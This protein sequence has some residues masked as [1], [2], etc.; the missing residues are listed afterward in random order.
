GA[1]VIL[2]G[3][4]PGADDPA[5]FQESVVEMVGPGAELCPFSATVNVVLSVVPDPAVSF[6]EGAAAMR[7]AAARAAEYLAA[8]AGG[9][10]ADAVE[11]FA[12]LPVAGALPRV[13]LIL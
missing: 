7:V 8:A 5:V 2:T 13:V 4:P 10:P 6:D 3:L 1:A 12:L 11:R 9:E